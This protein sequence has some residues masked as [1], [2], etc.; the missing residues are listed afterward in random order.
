[1]DP[2][3]VFEID[4][5]LDINDKEVLLSFMGNEMNA[6][7]VPRADMT[8]QGLD[9]LIADYLDSTGA[10][11]ISAT[12]TCG[13]RFTMS[14]T[15]VA[16]LEYTEDSR[17]LQPQVPL[18]R[19]ARFMPH[20]RQG[21]RQGQRATH[22]RLLPERVS[23]WLPGTRGP[24]TS[25]EGRLAMPSV[26]A[27]G[28][29]DATRQA[30]PQEAASTRRPPRTGTSDPDTQQHDDRGAHRAPPDNRPAHGCARTPGTCATPSRPASQGGATQRR[31]TCDH[32]DGLPANCRSGAGAGNYACRRPPSASLQ[33]D[34]QRHRGARG[35]TD[36][37]AA[38]GRPHAVAT[39]PDP[40]HG[41]RSLP[42]CTAD[43][44]RPQ[45]T[46]RDTDHCPQSRPPRS[47]RGGGQATPLLTGRR[48]CGATKRQ[49]GRHHPT[50]TE[51]APGSLLVFVGEV[52]IRKPRF[53]FSRRM[54][55]GEP[56]SCEVVGT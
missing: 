6:R 56:L 25:A 24:T 22:V 44:A 13:P 42:T 20:L 18:G 34:T 3:I 9:D 30:T 45:A 7:W 40:D 54:L 29:P 39:G 17:R 46:P 37:R 38:D 11:L 50:Q 48:P 52:P 16:R 21:G 4:R 47:R 36:A 2:S 43:Y 33:D 49:C 10:T 19:L 31:R 51:P 41:S 8:A 28:R 53:P 23:L 15:A 26:P 35:H 12:A 14:Q 5:I 32:P 27:A 55:P 1:M